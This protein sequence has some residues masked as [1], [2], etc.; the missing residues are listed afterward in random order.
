MIKN[1]KV[2][3]MS[4]PFLNLTR[5]EY[6]NAVSAR[7]NSNEQTVIFTPNP[8]MLLHAKRD[9][10]VQKLLQCADI[11]LPDGSGIILASKI[12]HSP[13][14]EQICGID[15]AEE[16]LSLA[17]Q[18]GLSVFL[19]GGRSGR[20]EEAMIRLKEKFPTLNVCGTYHGYFDK[21]GIE[22]IPVVEK[23][24]LA[25]PDI[26]FVC[27]GF[28][29]QESWIVQNVPA[30]PFCKLAIGLGGSIDVWSG[31]ARRSPLL[32]RKMRLEWL[33]RTVREPR[34][35]RIFWDIPA[36]LIA[37]LKEKKLKGD[38]QSEAPINTNI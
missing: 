20:A 23:I 35:I 29:Y 28:P 22:N 15:F 30:F 7:L 21:Q 9:A 14:C 6:V 38:P 24:V 13:L 32:F 10:S 12:L 19:L 27:F 34:R 26:I 5:E 18:N 3:I 16:L 36:F 11:T 2:E 1:A 4:V 25:K 33:W 37:V 8:Q 17:S 31:H